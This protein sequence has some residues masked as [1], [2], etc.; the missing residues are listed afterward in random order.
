MRT[1]FS[2]Y[3]SIPQ[4]SLSIAHGACPPPR[5][6]EATTFRQ[7][8]YSAC[9]HAT[10][11]HRRVD[12]HQSH[13]DSRRDTNQ[14][15]LSRCFFPQPAH[16]QEKRDTSDSRLQQHRESRQNKNYQVSRKR[17]QIDKT[18]PLRGHTVFTQQREPPKTPLDILQS[19]Q[20]Q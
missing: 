9:R 20:L 13:S 8:P 15:T 3:E 4:A 6:N 14:S 7:C 5:K 11:A 1:A 18:N 12:T 2:P 10:T 16:E 19:E 17:L